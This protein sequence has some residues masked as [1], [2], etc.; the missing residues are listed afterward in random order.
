VAGFAYAIRNIVAEAKKVEAAGRQV[1]YLNIGDPIQFGFATPPHLIE[2]VERAMREGHNGYGPSPG[3]AIAREAVARDYTAR[4]I[5]L[6]ADNIVLTAGASE[7]IDLALNALVDQ[8]DEVLVPSPDYPLYTA[9]LSQLG[10]RAVFYRTDPQRGWLPDLD[11][12]RSLIGP[13][14]RVLVLIDPNN[15]TG[16]VYPPAVRASLLDLA[17]RHGFV[18]LADEVYADLAHDGP[19]PLLGSLDRDAPVISLGSMSKAF[20]APGW[21]SGWLAIGQTDRLADALAAIRRLSDGRLC[22]TIPMQYALAS[23]LTGDRSGQAAFRVALGER[24]A[25]TTTRLNAI[26]GMR[27]VAPRGAFYA[28]PQVDLPPGK[29]D[30]DYVLGLLRAKGI[31]CVPG[32]GFNVG[33]DQGF[34][35]IVF[36][37]S[38]AEL[39]DIYDAMG[40]FTKEFLKM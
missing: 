20:L 21:R 15:P 34:F 35:R 26:P 1:R 40:A 17:N 3:I 6:P 13:R 37:A 24:A 12:V 30:E 32:A 38:P 10:G 7:G 28:M 8:G 4:G 9:V 11:H 2:A 36:L 39:S 27:C 23:A 14:T 29:Q 19:T 22:S 5:P 18:I 16:A 25:I 33:A 31:L